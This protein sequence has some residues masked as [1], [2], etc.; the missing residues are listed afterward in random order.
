MFLP[1]FSSSSNGEEEGARQSAPVLELMS[2]H[3]LQVL[4]LPDL[5][6]ETTVRIDGAQGIAFRLS[7]SPSH[8]GL[9]TPK[10]RLFAL[11]LLLYHIISYLVSYHIA[12]YHI[13]SHHII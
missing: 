1:I 6:E 3:G 5:P 12:S 4:L 8:A 2:P 9:K 7:A 11:V 10:C 13:I